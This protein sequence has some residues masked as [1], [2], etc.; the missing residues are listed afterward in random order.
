MTKN[1]SLKNAI[2]ERSKQT[3]EP[4]VVARRYIL[5]QQNQESVSTI[6]SETID[7]ANTS[8]DIV[9]SESETMVSITDAIPNVIQNIFPWTA[10]L[11]DAIKGNK[12]ISIM[13]ASG[14]VGKTTTSLC[15][16]GAIAKMFLKN[17]SKKKVVVVD[18]NLRE[19]KIASLIGRYM[20]TALS[21]RVLPK[22]DK[23]TVL[24]NLVH[25]DNLDIDI[26]LAPVQP[27]NA[28]DLSPD[29][30]RRVIE[31]LQSTHDVVILNCPDYYLNPFKIGFE[32]S[33]EVLLVTTL[34]TTSMEG[35]ARVLTELFTS[36]TKGGLGLDQRKV[37]I[38]GNQVA[39]NVGI[40][41]DRLL[42]AALGVPL[43]GQIP[44]EHDVVLMAS[45]QCKLH[46]LLDH[47]RLGPAYTSL[48]RM[49][50][51]ELEYI[52]KPK[53]N[54][55]LIGLDALSTNVYWDSDI[56]ANL[57]VGGKSGCGKSYFLRS[58][59]KQMVDSNSRLAYIVPQQR[60]YTLDG[61]ALDKEKDLRSALGIILEVDAI[62]NARYTI[63][64]N[65]GVNN[66][67]YLQNTPDLF[68]VIDEIDTLLDIKKEGVDA[69]FID[70]VTT[71]LKYIAMLGR[72]AGVRLIITSQNPGAIPESLLGN[73]DAR[74]ALGQMDEAYYESFTDLDSEY[75]LKSWNAD[76]PF[77]LMNGKEFGE[78]VLRLGNN[79]IKVTIPAL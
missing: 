56:Y 78:G 20:P 60:E 32:L 36:P 52:E 59:I 28:E 44:S 8:A 76:S 11:P 63:M 42:R 67:K 23:E 69:L 55:L 39:N 29:F 79:A 31:I 16:A 37:G 27:R 7:T 41:K 74:L 5:E 35:M 46:E 65:N 24:A 9:P 57:L 21:I 68:L 15:L 66:Y 70:R 48:A 45:N 73:L 62:M 50:L 51:P 72:A 40:G 12:T 61:E 43:V 14:G 54:K 2:R 30:Y 10:K 6:E 71:K 22:W 26:L 3:G 77:S 18:L 75:H 38:V 4:Y 19:G 49:C 34:A 64:Q 25:D 33:D 47:K 17:N 13:G 58:L 53:S 1:P